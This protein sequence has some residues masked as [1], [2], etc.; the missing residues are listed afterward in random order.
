MASSIPKIG[1]LY[2]AYGATHIQEAIH[3]LDS[4]RAVDS[5]AHVTLVSDRYV[6]G[7]DE[8]VIKNDIPGGFAGK[9]NCISNEYYTITFY[10]DTDT[11]ICSDPSGLFELGLYFDV[12]IMLDPAE[13]EIDGIA[14]YTA[15]NTGVMVLGSNTT[16]LL[17]RWRYHYNNDKLL[18]ELLKGHPAEKVKTDQPSFLTALTD[19]GVTIHSLPSIWNARYRFNISLM[20]KVKIIHGN[21]TD[22]VALEKKMNETTGNRC[23]EGIKHRGKL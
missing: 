10:L 19:A 23:W 16:E 7:F 13:V 12:S 8:L 18:A 3:S 11:Y 20:G 1:Y 22:F 14:G 2:T 21:T 9:V 4:L 5:K 17:K 15:Y 6:Q